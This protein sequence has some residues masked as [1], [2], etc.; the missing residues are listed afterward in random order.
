MDG[1]GSAQGG[2]E[3]EAVGLAE[4]VP[5]RGGSGAPAEVVVLHQRLAEQGGVLEQQA[6]QIAVLQSL[7]QA[8]QRGEGQGQ[9]EAGGAPRRSPASC[10]KW[11][12]RWDGTAGEEAQAAAAPAPAA[13]AAAAAQ[14]VAAQAAT[15]A[16]TAATTRQLRLERLKARSALDTATATN[17]RLLRELEG[18]RAQVAVL[19]E[20]QGQAEARERAQRRQQQQQ[21]GQ[22]EQRQEEEGEEGQEWGVAHYWGLTVGKENAAG[23]SRAGVPTSLQVRQQLAGARHRAAQLEIELAAAQARL[24]ILSGAS[25]RQ[26]GH[27]WRQDGR[28]LSID[29]SELAPKSLDLAAAWSGG[30][31][32]GG[33]SEIWASDSGAPPLACR[34]PRRPASPSAAAAQRL[35]SRHHLRPAA[36]PPPAHS[37]VPQQPQ[38]RGQQGQGQ[39]LPGLRPEQNVIQLVL[40]SAR[41]LLPALGSA[42]SAPAW[43][44]GREGQASSSTR[45]EAPPPV[46][47]LT[48]DF[49][50]HATQA[51]SL[52]EGST[53]TYDTTLQVGRRHV[54]QATPL[55]RCRWHCRRASTCAPTL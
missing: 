9:G 23:G 2:E 38:A 40:H 47:F 4:R 50:C 41:L 33:A 45:A 25:S 55:C 14:G 42:T 31:P 16:A 39:G 29:A 18:A 35:P 32:G 34:L 13:E 8:Q 11:R 54:S 52:G 5:G 21:G 28:C 36:P 10:A 19:L 30:W 24:A 44:P 20:H 1:G 6:R 49:F 46:T 27:G 26:G 3:G 12:G 15:G 43:R 51:T 37:T 48:A 22:R 17:T 53:P 7:M